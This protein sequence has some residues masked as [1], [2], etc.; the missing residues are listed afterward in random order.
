MAIRI[1]LASVQ[2]GEKERPVAEGAG[3][4]VSAF[5]YDS[6]IAALRVKNRRGEILVLPFKGHQIWRAAFDGRDLTMKSMFTEPVVTSTYLETYGAFFIHCGATAIGAPS[7]VDRHGLHGELPN[8]PYQ[9]GWVVIDEVLETCAVIGA[10]EYTVAFSYHY[11][12]TSTYAFGANDT[13]LDVSLQVDNLKKTPHGPDV[14]GPCQFPPGGQCRAHLFSTIHS[15]SRAG[16]PVDPRPHH[17]E[18]RLS[19]IPGAIGRQP[20][21]P[22]QADK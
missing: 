1:D 7:P 21:H 17:A 15:K 3:F 20:H 4:T 18:A 19:G 22:P 9:K 14:P 6:G 5:R 2:F 16:A 8:A 12:A 13:L 11:L 10:Y